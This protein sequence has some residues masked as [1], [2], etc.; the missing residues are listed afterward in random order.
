MEAPTK[1]KMLQWAG[2]LIMLLLSSSGI[3]GTLWMIGEPHVDSYLDKKMDEYHEHDNAIHIGVIV[4]EGKEWYIGPDGK[5]HTVIYG[6]DDFRWWY[7]D[8]KMK[9]IYK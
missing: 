2:R 9:Q 3:V 8:G 7:D 1:K 5:E 6:E 4:R